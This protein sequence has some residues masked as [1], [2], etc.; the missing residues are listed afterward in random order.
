MRDYEFSWE[1]TPR[2]I[3]YVAELTFI[4]I[5]TDECVDFRRGEGGGRGG[6]RPRGR[7]RLEVT[8]H[9]SEF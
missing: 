2:A 9:G 8:G 6:A 5:I 4:M 7:V 3:C 1:T